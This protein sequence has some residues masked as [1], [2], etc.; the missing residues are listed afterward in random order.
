MS[1][2]G[3][4]IAEAQAK[5]GE[6]ASLRM[7]MYHGQGRIRDP[8][9]LAQFDLVSGMMSLI[10]SGGVVGKWLAFWLYRRWALDYNTSER[11][12]WC[13]GTR[14]PP[15]CPCQAPPLAVLRCTAWCA[16][17]TC[18]HSCCPLQVVTTY[19]T[20][21]SDFG[22]KKNVDPVSGAVLGPDLLLRRL[23]W[24]AL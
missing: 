4:W 24:A 18:P 1:L 2:V 12:Q 19:A 21:G 13:W 10:G 22:G 15:Q 9:R 5:L 3:Q 8:A 20:L 14:H 11:C 17:S 23:R 7:H 16:L 6:H